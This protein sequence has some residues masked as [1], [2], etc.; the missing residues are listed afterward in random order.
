[1]LITTALTVFKVKL[2]VP[3]ENNSGSLTNIKSSSSFL[4]P[5]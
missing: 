4:M 2:I 3:I 5:L 1:M